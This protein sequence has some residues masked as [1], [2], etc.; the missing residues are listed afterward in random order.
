MKSLVLL[1]GLMGVS[2]AAGDEELVS[3]FHGVRPIFKENCVSCHRVE[4]PKHGLDLT[5]YTGVIKGSKDGSILSRHRLL[6]SIQGP[7]PEMPPPDE[8][9]PLRPKEVALIERWIAQGA[10]DDTPE[11]A[12]AYM[13]PTEPPVYKSLPAIPA[14]A[15]SP[16]GKILAVS[17]HHEIVLWNADAT[18]VVGRLLGDSPRLESIEFSPDGKRLAASGGIPYEF[19]EVQIWDVSSQKQLRSIKTSNDV[20]Y[21]I[22]WSPDQHLLAIGGADKLVRAFAVETGAEV[23]RCDNHIDWV[24]GTAFTVDGAQLVS[25][26]RDH[27]VKLIDVK[28]GHLIDDI[29]RPRGPVFAIGRHPTESIVAFGG[30]SDRIFLHRMEP[31]GGR[32]SER[33]KNSKPLN[34]IR[35]FEPVSGCNAIEFAPDGQSIATATM[36][37]E[38]RLISVETGKRTAM[39]NL[40]SPVFDLVYQTANIVVAAAQDGMLRWIDVEKAEI[41]ATRPG[42]PF[43]NVE[44]D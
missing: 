37:G 33:E 29:N 43:Q 2:A 10:L 4:K 35:E 30:D 17:G 15:V 38:V 9:A 28:T 36:A 12:L 40:E 19:G 3:W 5:T 18:E 42:V 25:V 13:R 41:L 7:E 31:A 32:L 26:S 34:F 6:E 21:G 8:G 27:L 11:G 22:S 39:A 20:F 23:M 16:D 44:P 24:F 1:L 14:I